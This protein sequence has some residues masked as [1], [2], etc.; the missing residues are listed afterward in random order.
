MYA[1]YAHHGRVGITDK[2][3]ENLLQKKG[4]C[5][6]KDDPQRRNTLVRQIPLALMFFL[7]QAGMHILSVSM[8]GE[9]TDLTASFPE[10]TLSLYHKACLLW[11]KYA[12]KFTSEKNWIQLSV[13]TKKEYS[14][15]E[16]WVFRLK[17]KQGIIMSWSI[18]INSTQE[19]LP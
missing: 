7:S 6:V 12:Y 16:I 14:N 18:Q 8:P 11:R 13:L 5:Q 10:T 3:R 17:D 4:P 1:K 9:V 2:R 15:F 19:V